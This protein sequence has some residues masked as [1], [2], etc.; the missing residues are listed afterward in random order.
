[1][2]L[3][4]Y[5][6]LATAVSL[7]PAEALDGF[8]T[9]ASPDDI[10]PLPY[11]YRDVLPPLQPTSHYGH[12]NESV[13]P[14]QPVPSRFYNSTGAVSYVKQSCPLQS[15][16]EYGQLSASDFWLPNVAHQ[17]TSPFLINGSDYQVYRDVTEFG[18][19]GDGVH[20]DSAAFNNAILCKSQRHL[21][22]AMLPP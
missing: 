10:K 9:P 7:S 8:L 3:S 11:S 14:W 4:G 21:R 18:A 17:G 13:K 19:K 20:D 22:S 16:Q 1:M 5:V 12:H 15:K 6:L 2:K